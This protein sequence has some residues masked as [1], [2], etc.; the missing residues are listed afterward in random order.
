LYK[1][2]QNA[3]TPKIQKTLEEIN[4]IVQH[5][6]TG[7]LNSRAPYQKEQ[8]TSLTKKEREKKAKV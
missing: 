8:T 1:E 2:I 3:E 5:N 7:E 4:E 6:S